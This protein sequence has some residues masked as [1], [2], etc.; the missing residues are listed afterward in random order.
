M[1][2]RVSVAIQHHPSREHLVGPLLD[3]L[4]GAEV[5]TD[6]DPTG[7][8]SPLR[9]YLEALRRTPPDAT[10]RLVVQDDALPCRGFPVRM[11]LLVA[12]R[13][14]VL[15]PLFLPGAAPH[16][17]VVLLASKAGERWATLDPTWIP[18]VALVWPV[19]MAVRFLA[20]ADETLDPEKRHG[21]D[22][23]VGRWAARSRVRAVGPVPSIVQH[24]DVEP[25][26]IGR[27]AGAGRNRAR[28]AARFIDDEG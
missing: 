24:P 12:E 27:R 3:A 22:G 7:V 13:P 14:D 19:E 26:T 15:M 6:P 18:T 11:G 28:V 4:G 10:H 16:R 8:R 23:P 2:V 20:W 21:D 25:S 9:T 17:R 5:V 1:T